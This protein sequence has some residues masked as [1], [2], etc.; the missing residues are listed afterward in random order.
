MVKT[1]A[2]RCDYRTQESDA[3]SHHV[4]LPGPAGDPGASPRA[5]NRDP[6]HPLPERA[7]AA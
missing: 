2:G 3:L 7:W 6:H 4:D 1:D 5:T